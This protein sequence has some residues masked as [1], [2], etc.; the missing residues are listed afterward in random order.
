LSLWQH[1]HDAFAELEAAACIR[2]PVIPQNCKHNA[3]MYYLLLGSL[4]ERSAFIAAMKAEN[5]M[6]VFHYV[7][8][9]QSPAGLKF[10]R[11][12]GE[13]KHTQNLSERLVRLPL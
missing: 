10:C 5:I 6:T 4:N 2:R 8:L 3:H 7:P 13:L 9:H 1:Y 11:T 12:H